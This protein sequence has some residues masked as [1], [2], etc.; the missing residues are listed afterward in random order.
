MEFMW[1]LCFKIDVHGFL[2]LFCSFGSQMQFPAESDKN[3]DHREGSER[4][5]N[6]ITRGLTWLYFCL[7]HI[8]PSPF[9][10][11]LGYKEIQSY[12][13]VQAVWE[14]ES[15]GGWGLQGIQSGRKH[16]DGINLRF[17]FLYL[18]CC[19]EAPSPFGRNPPS[20]WL[21]HCYLYSCILKTPLLLE[22]CWPSLEHDFQIKTLSIREKQ[23]EKSP[24]K[25]GLLLQSLPCFTVN[26]IITIER[27][28]LFCQ[29]ACCSL[30]VRPLSNTSQCQTEFKECVF[31]LMGLLEVSEQVLTLF[32]GALIR[33][34]GFTGAPSFLQTHFFCSSN[35]A[36]MLME[37]SLMLQCVQSCGENLDIKG[38]TKNSSGAQ[39]LVSNCFTFS[40]SLPIVRFFIVRS[41]QLFLDFKKLDRETL[42]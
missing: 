12:L 37:I 28:S 38:E 2:T 15:N 4:A 25:L 11:Q 23:I 8:F 32:G 35:M 14:E 30:G 26:L 1:P 31:K 13:S 3:T 7:Q 6:D 17:F 5:S 42:L 10:S 40:P 27:A 36:V 16:S 20:T 22:F 21:C 24:K 29:T 18:I 9:Q 39:N 41:R 19:E 34:A 33:E